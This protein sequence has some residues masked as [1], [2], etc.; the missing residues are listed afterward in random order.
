MSRPV[1]AYDLGDVHALAERLARR[2]AASIGARSLDILHVAAA[3]ALD[4]EPFV[5]ADWR[6]VA[7]AKAVGLN[8]RSLPSRR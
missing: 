5:T 3:L 4:A 1:P 8:S 2:Y 7:L 6:Q